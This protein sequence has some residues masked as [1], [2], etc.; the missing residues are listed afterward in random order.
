MPMSVVGDVKSAGQGS[1]YH[2]NEKR[3]LRGSLQSSKFDAKTGKRPAKL[4]SG[5]HSA[6]V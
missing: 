5:L 6:K 4:I 2:L 3:Y 1:T